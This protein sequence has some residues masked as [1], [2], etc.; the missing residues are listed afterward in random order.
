VT[1][2]H[3]ACSLNLPRLTT[4]LLAAGAVST[5]A[6]PPSPASSCCTLLASTCRPSPFP[7]PLAIAI[8]RPG[9]SLLSRNSMPSS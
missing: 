4:M 1:A 2:L 3:A 6:V 8:V 9:P 5:R 7:S